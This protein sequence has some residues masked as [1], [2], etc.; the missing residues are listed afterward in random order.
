[1]PYT[2]VGV[3][4][5]PFQALF[6]Q[7]FIHIALDYGEQHLVAARFCRGATFEPARGEV[8]C[9][10]CLGAG[11]AVFAALV[12]LHYYV[13]AEVFLY[14]YRLFGR[15]QVAGT[16]DVRVEVYSLLL[17]LVEFGEGEYLEAAAVGQ[18]RA[19]PVHKLVKAARLFY[20][21]VAG[22]HI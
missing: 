19:V 18:D 15:E 13:G 1:M 10:L 20:N 12:E 21:L 14:G 7:V 17:Y 6:A 9:I 3:T 11:V 22:A 8:H 5:R 2:A 4:Y 16:V